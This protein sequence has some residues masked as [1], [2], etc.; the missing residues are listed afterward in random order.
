MRNAFIPTENVNL[1]SD[2]CMELESPASHI[3]PSLAIAS[4]RAGRGKSEA[5]KQ[6]AVQNSAV[7]LPPMNVRSPLMLLRE[8]TFELCKMKPGRIELCLDLISDEMDRERRLI[9]ID[10][11]DLLPM[12]ILEMLRNINERCG[13]PMLLIGEEG[14]KIKIASRRRLSSRIR[15]QMSFGPVG[16]SDIVVFFRKALEIAISPAGV[17]MIHAHA[18]GDWRPVLTVAADLERALHASGITHVPDDLIQELTR[19]PKT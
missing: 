11:A 2:I 15:R 10:E 18:E 9:M 14:L 17:A 13:C 19:G 5:A 7:Y 1:L 3:G 8:I 16:Q 4:G 6:Y 12:Q